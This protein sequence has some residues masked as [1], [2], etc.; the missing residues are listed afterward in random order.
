MK[1]S[2]NQTSAL[3]KKNAPS[4]SA[5]LRYIGIDP[6]TNVLGYAVIEVVEQ[7]IKLLDIGVLKLGHLSKHQWKLK[8][9]FEHIADLID[10]YFPNE[11]AI[12]APFY[13][14]NV[15]S[16]LKLGRAQG[17]AI[18]A[19]ITQGVPIVEYAPK[20]IKQSVTG[21]GNA[22]KEQVAAMLT[23]ILNLSL[24]DQYLDATDA[25]AA[26]VCHYYQTQSVIG[27]RKQHGD[28][29][30]FLKDNPKRVAIK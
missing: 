5:S 6:G 4:V 11:M 7:K 17:V 15:Q 18:A 14:K 19:A 24:S 26:A 1:K 27:G 30:S 20:K 12:E 29:A 2:D 16:M 23:N 9:I 8:K 28:W 21:N 10:R 3:L 13:G 22:A 25:L